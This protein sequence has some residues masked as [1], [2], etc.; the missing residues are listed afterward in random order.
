MKITV[1]GSGYVGLV[2]AACFSEV[3]LDV[4]CMDMDRAKIDAL[5]AGKCPIYEPSL[6]EL[7]ERNASAGR[8]HFTTDLEV[9]LTDADVAFIAVSATYATP[10]T[11]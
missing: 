8:L 6:P 4:W 10:R 2:T 11:P 1:I 7:L 5:N 3:G 9:C